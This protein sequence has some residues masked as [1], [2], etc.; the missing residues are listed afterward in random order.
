[1][2]VTR[3]DM[4]LSGCRLVGCRSVGRQAQAQVQAHGT[5]STTKQLQVKSI[6]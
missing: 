6:R 4:A 5:N 1:M 2:R 3:L